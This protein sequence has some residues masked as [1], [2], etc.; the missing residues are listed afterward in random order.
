MT[1]TLRVLHILRAPDAGLFRH[2]RD[3][4]LEQVRWGLDV[5][6]LCDAESSSGLAGQLLAQLE[7]CLPLG[8]HVTPMGRSP[9]VTDIRAIAE[10]R[11]LTRELNI[12]VLHGHGLKGGLFSR[13]GGTLPAGRKGLAPLRFYSPHGRGLRHFDG[14]IKGNVVVSAEVGLARLTD[15]LIFDSAFARDRYA[16]SVNLEAVPNRVIFNGLSEADFAP[17][18]LGDGA[19]EFLFVGE[20][21][22]SKGGDVLLDALHRLDSSVGRAV[23]VGGGPEAAQLKAQAHRLGLGARV[24][25]AGAMPLPRALAMGKTLVIPSRAESLPYIALEAA[26]AGVPMVATKVGGVPEIIEGS[27]TRLV[28]VN[29]PDAL[30]CAMA[31][32]ADDFEAAQARAQRLRTIV[33]ERFSTARMVRS[34]L[35][36]YRDG[37]LRISTVG[38]PQVSESAEVYCN[39]ENS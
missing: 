8:L 13:L 38:A 14:S 33:Q 27:D 2:V 37:L 5:G 34:V 26:A 30:A 21:L 12:D 6:V 28:P 16:G 31:L 39:E 24:T 35:E 17:R 9:G 15:G 7:P 20:L 32:A 18:E 1:H 23:I 29:D 11:R 4:A 3:V 25:F 19:A 10:A 22:R 36:F